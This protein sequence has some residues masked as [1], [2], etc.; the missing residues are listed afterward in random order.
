MKRL[1]NK[2]LSFFNI[3]VTS[4][5]TFKML[6]K[7]SSLADAYAL[8]HK[9]NEQNH[10]NFIK[11]FSLSR[12]ELAQDLFVLSEFNFKRNGF[13]VEFGATNGIE[14][15][16][17]YLLEKEF[18]WKGILAEPAKIWHN[19]LGKNRNVF[20]EKDCV[21]KLSNKSLIF[22]EVQ[23]PKLSTINYHTKSDKHQDIRKEGKKYK[24][25][26]ISLVDLL[27][28]Y[29]APKIIDYLSIDTEGSEYEILSSFNF[30][31]YTVK[32]IT[33]EHN[34]TS[35]RDKIFNLL[36]KKGYVRKF[37]DVSQFD[38]WY[39]LVKN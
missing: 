6:C 7:K 37:T 5:T 20:I 8:L 2:L 21:W 13:F 1:I 23:F 35:N 17:S 27:Q 31:K 29:N 15:S 36:L 14:S 10:K 34:F 9:I 22:N 33:C 30:E 39:V 4:A 24:V 26:T 18:G 28:K 12:S 19:E 25:N 38:D 3:R 32:V 11:N 16:N